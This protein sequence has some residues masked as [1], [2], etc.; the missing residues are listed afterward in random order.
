MLI[1]P[2][3]WSISPRMPPPFDGDLRRVE[4][5][6]GGLRLC[7]R[8]MGIGDEVPAVAL[9]TADLGTLAVESTPLWPT[10]REALEA[11]PSSTPD[12]PNEHGEFWSLPSHQARA[13]VGDR[14]ALRGDR[15][16]GVGLRADGLPD[17]DWR[18]V[19]PRGVRET[20]TVTIDIR[21]NE[22][23]SESE[24]VDT[25]SQT[26]SRF[27]IACYPV[28]V[29]QFR[30]FLEQCY[31]DGHWRLPGTA[32]ALGE[33]YPP[34]KPR[35]VYDN[36]PVDSVNWLDA[37]A[38]CAWLSE[39]L[40]FEVRLPTEF[41]WQLA[42][43]GGDPNRKYPWAADWDPQSEPWR[44]NTVE[45]ELGRSTAVGLYPR[46][47]APCGALDMGGTLCEWCS[48]NFDEPKNSA[49]PDDWR[50]D[51]R[52]LRGGSWNFNQA[53]ARCASR[54]R[55][56]PFDRNDNNGFRLL[57]VSHIFLVPSW[58]GA[59]RHRCECA[60]PSKDRLRFRNCPPAMVCGP[61]RGRKDGAGVSPPHGGFRAVRR[62]YAKQR[63][64][65][66]ES[67]EAPR[68]TDMRG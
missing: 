16:R 64:L 52:A 10:D 30:A 24:V 50:S 60:G 36:Q 17:I 3:S 6:R 19:V 26:V 57:C 27:W 33:G 2:A 42:T 11:L 13:K 14:L 1:G 47:V 21:S 4:T 38:F 23:D 28:T 63:R 62:A 54:N 15:R 49:W 8:E 56:S 44:A 34:P 12:D 31:K 43:T 59:P 22:N 65:P 40:G 61:R 35:A 39:A 68:S 67:P 5:E 18:E 48:N 37:V 55:F 9:D 20:A 53:W 45:S 51:R 66:G 46:G 32:P 7:G 58:H 25:L 29:V 41:E